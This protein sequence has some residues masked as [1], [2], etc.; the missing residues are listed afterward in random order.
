MGPAVKVEI[1]GLAEETR[2]V[3]LGQREAPAPAGAL[4][5]DARSELETIRWTEPRSSS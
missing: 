4:G 5:P 2:S 3:S 1:G